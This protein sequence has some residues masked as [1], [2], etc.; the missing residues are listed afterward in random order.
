MV[1]EDGIT[2]LDQCYATKKGANVIISELLS[3]IK[4]RFGADIT[5]MTA[6]EIFNSGYFTNFGEKVDMRDAIENLKIDY[7]INDV[8]NEMRSKSQEL[9]RSVDAVVFG[10]GGAYFLQA[11]KDKLPANV[12]FAASPMEF[13]NVR[14]YFLEGLK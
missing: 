5:E 12:V 2:R 8:L 3:V 1:F 7:A 9:L 6:K 11:V 10:G 4:R 14:G 13:S